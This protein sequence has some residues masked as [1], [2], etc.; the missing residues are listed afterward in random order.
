MKSEVKVKVTQLCP[1]LCDPIVYTVHGILQARVLG[2][3]VILFSRGFPNPEIEP[4]SFTLQVDSLPSETP[5][6]P[7]GDGNGYPLWYSGLENSMDCID[8]GGHKKLDTTEWLSLSLHS[9]SGPVLFLLALENLSTR[10]HSS[11]PWLNS[12]VLSHTC[13]CLSCHFLP[14]YSNPPSFLSP[15]LVPLSA[16]TQALDSVCYLQWLIKTSAPMIIVKLIQY[17][18]FSRSLSIGFETI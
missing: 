10:I 12:L 18:K 15:N 13:P 16:T 1:T 11:W 14:F 3:V 7:H 8:H 17:S 4:R 9:S 5:R 2:W 6:K